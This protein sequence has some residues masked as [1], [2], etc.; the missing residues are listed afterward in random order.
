VNKAFRLLSAI[1][2]DAAVVEDSLMTAVFPDK[3][4]D[5]RGVVDSESA[6]NAGPDID[7]RPEGEL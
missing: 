5:K 1:S 6:L 4:E 7:S 2:T 3:V